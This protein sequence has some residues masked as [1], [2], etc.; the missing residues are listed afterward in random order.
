MESHSLDANVFIEAFR[1]YYSFE[2]APTFWTSLE[3]AAKNRSVLGID[4]IYTEL[5][6]GNDELADWAKSKWIKNFEKTSDPKTV[7]EYTKLMIWAQANPQ[8]T[9]QAKTEFAQIADAWL[10]AHAMAN[11]YVVVT[12]EAYNKEARKRILIPNACKAFGVSYC[13]TFVMLRKLKIVL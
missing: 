11:N 7:K 3:N 10:V 5:E 2:I 12:H 13:D 6:K 4:R 8:Y 1:R 9:P